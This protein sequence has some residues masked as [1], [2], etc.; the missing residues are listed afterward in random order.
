LTVLAGYLAASSETVLFI[1]MLV[2][3]KHNHCYHHRVLGFLVL[4]AMLYTSIGIGI[5]Y[6]CR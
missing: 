1:N 2:F 4:I 5:G 6:W 3:I